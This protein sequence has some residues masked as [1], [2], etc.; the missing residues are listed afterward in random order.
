MKPRIAVI[1]LGRI[2]WLMDD[3]PL[4]TKPCTHVGAYLN[5]GCEIVAGC[6]IR[7]DRQQLF[8]ERFDVQHVYNDYEDMLNQH[9][10]DGL[11]IC[12]YA[13]ERRA[14]VM[15]AIRRNVPAIF[16][17]KAFATSLEEADEMVAAVKQANTR[18]VVA[19]MRRW[20]PEYQRVKNML[21]AGDLGEIQSVNVM[22]SGSL[23]HTGTHAF[24]VLNWWFGQPVAVRGKVFTKG[25][26]DK[27]SGYRFGMDNVG[28]AGGIGQVIYANDIIVNI[29]GRVKNYFIFEMDVIGT[30][31]R[32]RI[33]NDGMYFFQSAVSRQ[34]SGFH[35]LAPRTIEMPMQTG[36][37]WDA[38]VNVVLPT[39]NQRDKESVPPSTSTATDARTALEIAMGFFLSDNRGGSEV[40]FPLERTGLKISSR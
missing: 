32:I 21:D 15:A 22:F 29:E 24:D 23:I 8:A 30:E 5:R 12:A 33:G 19:H 4:R 10:L 27:E 1:G 18:L 38:A 7:Q 17:E 9:E 36:T 34:V 25:P 16:C 39:I 11:S 26:A 6:D 2:A 35:E 40:G 20:V 31:G 13:T 37:A 14:M 28:D 3:D